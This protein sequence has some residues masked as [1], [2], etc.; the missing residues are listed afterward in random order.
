M[1]TIKRE[2]T[3][4][5]ITLYVLVFFTMIVQ[6]GYFTTS[7]LIVTIGL[8]AILAWRKGTWQPDMNGIL[9][10]LLFGVMAASAL[11]GALD[12]QVAITELLKY[13]LFPLSYIVFAGVK[14]KVRLR[15][16]FHRSFM[17]L[18]VF[19]LLAVVGLSVMSGMVTVN[20]NRLQ[21]FLQYANTTALFMGIGALFSLDRYR[22]SKK[23]TDLVFSVLFVVALLLTESR[24]TFVLFGVILTVYVFTFLGRKAKLIFA[25]G[26]VAVLVLLVA[27]GGRIIRLSLFE[28]TL[29]ERV[30]TFQDALRIV[31]MK[32]FGLGL[33]VGDWQF[34]QFIYQ[35]APYQ[36]RYV[37]NFF[38]QVALDGGLLALLLVIVLMVFNLK[39]AMKTGSV[40][41]YVFLFLLLHSL[42][43]VDFSF[44]IVILF[45]AFLLT[46][47]GEPSAVQLPRWVKL[48]RV[49]L[50][51]P[52]IALG[53]MLVSQLVMS[54]G[55]RLLRVQPE[56]A[57]QRYQMA[58]VINPL[59]RELLFKQAKA[60]RNI[61]NALAMLERSYEQ[62][63]H[64]TQVLAALTEGWLYANNME[65][66][67]LYANELFTTF[68]YSRKSQESVRNVLEASRQSGVLGEDE[69][70]KGIARL[71]ERIDARNDQINPLYRY[72]RADMTY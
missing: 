38:L 30:I 2:P 39:R 41:L 7:L 28:P 32:T 65:K 49:T 62:N 48:P 67:Q 33:G 23:I 66:A 70:E 4:L 50:V 45:F 15:T 60:E 19:G 21:S 14:D 24:T 71:Q 36:V 22:T 31:F 20:G 18:A 53:V 17:L 64:D 11:F 56:E 63:R 34:M 25:G 1:K 58:H 5:Y 29:I 61:G 68:P 55:D 16:I 6:G 26:A 3:A 46:C 8:L 27:V 59:N 40:Y 52:I 12:A 10:L 35:S 44:G 51:I 69:Y 57:L 43:E 47:L 42:F 72:I 37:H 9:L 54:S 13:A